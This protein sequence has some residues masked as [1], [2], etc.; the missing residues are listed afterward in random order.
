MN[1]KDIIALCLF[2]EETMSTV[3][4][5]DAIVAALAKNGYEILLKPKGETPEAKEIGSCSIR[6]L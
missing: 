1:P 3:R 5:A 2:N 6:Y 4:R